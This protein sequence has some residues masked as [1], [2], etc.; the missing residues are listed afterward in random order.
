MSLLETIRGGPDLTKTPTSIDQKLRRGRVARDKDAPTRR[1]CRKFWA[2]EQYWLKTAAGSLTFQ[3][4]GST[5]VAARDKTLHRIRNT[6]NY[7]QIIVEAKVSAA[8]QRVPGYEITPSTDDPE[9]EAAASLASQVAI[10]GYDEWHIR[11]HTIKV[12]TNALVSREGFL[13]PYFDPNVGPYN[14]QGEGR[15]EVRIRSLSREQVMWEKDT[16]FDDSR[17]HAIEESR[18]VEDIKEIPGYIKGSLDPDNTSETVNVTE[19]LERPCKTYPSGRRMFLAEGRPIVNYQDDPE[20][21]PEWTDWWE[22]Y[23]Y[24]DAKGDVYDAPVIHR[25]SYTV[26][27]DQEADDLGLVER[28]IDPQ[29]TINDCANKVLEIKNRALLLQILAPTGSQVQRRD[30]TPGA[31]FYYNAT[32][33]DKPEWEQPPNPSFIQQLMEIRRAAVEEIRALSAD[34]DVQPEARL[35]EGT[36]AQ[37]VTQSA[38]RWQSF[39]GDLAEFHSRVMRHCLTLAARYYSEERQIDIRGQYGWQALPSFKGQDMRSQV[40]VRVLP[41]SLETKS[42]QAIRE[43]IAWIAA[44]F[45]GAISAEAALGVLHGGSAEGLLR[46]YENHVN[47]AW[48][49]VKRLQTGPDALASF[50]TRFDPKY[51]NIEAI[52]AAQAGTPLIDPVTG[53]PV[54]LMGVDVPVWMPAPWDN[55]K[56][57]RQVFGDHMCTEFFERQPEEV[58][59]NFEEIWAGLDLAEKTRAAEQA[60][61]QQMQAESLGMSNAAKDQGPPPLPD[62]AGFTPENSSPVP[63]PAQA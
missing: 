37:A 55:I 41:G 11:R 3:T 8:T 23:P 22:P 13:M 21:D 6:Y 36:A 51:P 4:P 45:P 12:V 39:L 43:E 49:I 60:A 38:A 27:P 63:E 48:R 47:R 26:N 28:L 56:I 59:H 9:D 40:N 10:Y 35:A 16:D 54:P 31:T 58:R 32:G 14:D 1:L 15:G 7:I 44:T 29:R 30:D 24:M 50:G 42:R 25:I 53:Q 2:G 52:T 33:G 61:Q 57:W 34:V 5:G 19:Y 46:S 20:C 18:R 17:W 62:R